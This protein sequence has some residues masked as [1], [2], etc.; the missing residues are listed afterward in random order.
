MRDLSNKSAWIKEKAKEFGFTAVGF[1]KAEF[2]KD[3]AQKLREWLGLNYHGEMKYLEDHFDKRTDPTKLVE[4]SKTVISL[5]YNYFTPEKQKDP[6]APKIS[7]YAYGRDYHKVV[8]K[9]L[10]NLAKEMEVEFGSFKYRCFIDSA[11]ILERDWAKRSGLGWVGKHTLIINPKMGSY[12]FLAEIIVDFELDYDEP[13]ADYCGTCTKCIEACP[14][15]AISKEGYLMDGGKCISYLNIEYKKGPIPDEF[16][17]K[18]ENWVYGCDICQDVCPW[19]RF[20]K[21]HNEKD[22]KPRPGLLEM[23][24]KDWEDMTSEQFDEVFFGSPV[25]RAGF[26]K[27]KKNIL[28]LSE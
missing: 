19:N 23:S 28:Y 6:E 14:T 17:G 26:V 4:T 25:K 16:K 1:A 22:F 7:M 3:E 10:L 13:I 18:M 9:K 8:K 11:P 20:S 12:F 24:K 5:A 15:D 27:V 21:S 2:M